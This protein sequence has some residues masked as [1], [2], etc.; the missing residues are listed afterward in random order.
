MDPLPASYYGKLDKSNPV[1]SSFEKDLKE[2]KLHMKRVRDS[3]S[4]D[5]SSFSRGSMKLFDIWKKYEPRLPTPYFHERLLQIADFLFASKFFRLAQWQGY[6]RYLHHFCTSGLE[7]IKDVEQ[8]KQSFFPEGFV[9]EGAKLMFH[10]LQGECLCTF[11]LERERSKRP[12]PSGLQKLLEILTF[13]RI[14]MQAILPH[15]SLCWLLYN[16]SLH[17]YNICR[18]LMSV[19]HAAQALEYLLWACVCLETSVPLLMPRFLPWRATLY[20]AV[21]ECYY[22]GQAAVQAEVFARRALGKVS[23]LG[24]LEELSGSPS[25]AETQRAF[26]EATIKLAVMVF[27]RSVYEPRKKP[28]GLFRPKQKSSLK[29]GHNIPW[30]RTLTEQILMELFE[31]NAAQFLAVLEGLWDSSCRPLHTGMSDEPEIQEVALELIS[32]GIS[33]LSGNGGSSYRIY[34]ESLPPSLNA[35]TSTFTLMEMA[36][37]GKNQIPV[38]SAVK[39]V[40]LLFRYEQWD[41]F[42]SL[43][44]NLMAVLSNLEGHFF[45]KAE[46]ELTL[47]EALE[48]LLL[49]HKVRLGNKDPV[50]TEALNDKDKSVGQVTMTDELLNLVLTL[51]ACVCESAQDIQVD[52]DMVLDIVLFL[53]AKCK[54]VFQRAQARHYDQV[55]YLGKTENQDKWVQTLFLLCEVAQVCQLAE[56]DPVM[57]AEMT[58]RLAMVLESSADSPPQSGIKTASTEYSSLQS[59]P[60]EKQITFMRSQEE[61][62]KMACGVLE[63]GLECLSRGR[64]ASLPCNASAIS[65]TVFLQKCGDAPQSGQPESTSISSVSAL[66]MDLHVELLA[67]HHRVFLKLLDTFPDDENVEGIKKSVV[68]PSE[69]HSKRSKTES[70]LLEKIKKNKVSK[71]LFLIQKALLSYRKDPTSRSTKKLLEEAVVLMEKA[72][73]EEKR[74]AGASS[75]AEVVS[76]RE[77]GS[78]PPPPPVLLSC[79]DWSMTFTPAVYTL[80]EKVCWYRIYGREV[81]GRNYKVRIGDGHLPGTGDTVP[82]RG[83]PLFHISGLETNQKYIFA[84]AAY[85][86]KGNLV[87]NTIG[88]TTRPLLASLPLPLLSTWAHLAQV[89]YRTGQHT[90]AKKACSVIWSHFMLPSASQEPID[91]KEPEGLA[92][93]RLHPEVLKLSSPLMQQFFLSSIFIQTDIHIQERALYCDTLWDESILIWGQEARLA[94]CERMLVAIDLALHLN[95][96]SAA[97]QAIVSCY[98]LLA[99]LVYYQIPSDPVIQVLLKCLMVLQEI[100]AVLKQKR[101]AAT[102]ESLHHMVACITYY[103]AKGLRAFKEYGMASSV[104]EQG[105]KLLQEIF[106]N[107]HQPPSRPAQVEHEGGEKLQKKAVLV[108]EEELC[109][110]LKSLE[111]SALKHKN[112]EVFGN[113]DVITWNREGSPDPDL[114]GYEDPVVLH[115]VI[116]CSP[117]RNAFKE[118]MKFKHK[119]CFIEF[120]VFLLQRAL[121]EDQLELLPQWGQEIF[122][123][124]SRRDEGLIVLKKPQEKMRK[125]LKKFTSSVIEYSNKKQKASSFQSDKQKKVLKKLSGPGTHTSENMW[126]GRDG[127]ALETLLKLLT[128]LVRRHQRRRRL[129]KVCSDEWPWR[130]HINLTLAQAYMGLLKKSREPQAGALQRCYSKMSPLLF[131]LAH[132]G[133]LVKWKHI[134][135][136]LSQ[137]TLKAIPQPKKD[138]VH[139]AKDSQGATN[140]V[141]EETGDSEVDSELDSPR[142]QMTNDSD[143]SEP[144]VPTTLTQC[145]VSQPLDTLVKALVHLRRAMVLAHRGH[146]W[147]SLQW[148]CR[149][150]WDEFSTMVLLVERD[151]PSKLTLD[152]FCTVFTPLLVLASDLLMDMMQRLQQWKVYDGEGE[153][154]EARPLNDGAL[155]DLRWLRN[156]VLH[157]LEL[158]YHQAKWETLANLALVYNS[159]TR[160]HY[161]HMI[162]PVLVHAQRRLL[163]R[164]TYYGGPPVPQPHFIHTETATGEKISCRNYAGKQLFL[165]STSSAEGQHKGTEST[166][167]SE[168]LE[169]AEVRRAMCVV[170][171]PLDI[172]DTLCCFRETLAKSCYTLLTFQHSRTLLKLLLA[173]TQDSL[174][175]SFCKELRRGR[176]EFNIAATTAPSIGPPDLTN[177][178]YSTVGSVYSSPLPLSHIQ[179]VISSYNSSIKYLQANKYTSLQVQALHDLGNLH[180]CNG[181]RKAAH[182]HWSKALDCA[183]QTTGVLE[184][185]DAESWASSSSQQPLAHAGIWGCLQGA[186]LSAK[187]AQYILTSNISQHTKCCLLSAKLFKCLLKASLPHPDNDLEYSSYSIKMELI[188]GA[189]LF[190]E[191][192]WDIAASAVASLG[193]LCRSLYASGHQLMILPLLALYQYIAT[194]VCQDPHLTVGCRILKVKVLT[195]LGLFAEAVTETYSLILGEEVPLFHRSYTGAEKAWAQKKFTNYKPVMDPSNLEAL[196]EVVNRRPS[197]EIMALYGNSLTCHLLLARIQLIVVICN[198][199][200]DLPE[201]LSPEVLESQVGCCVASSSGLPGKESPCRSPTT[202]SKEAQ[203]LQLDPQKD[204]LTLGQVKALMLREASSQL[205]SQLFALQN[206]HTGP[207]ELELAVET[208]LLLSSLSLQQGKTAH[209]ANL[210]ASALRLLQNSP[211][212]QDENP[213]HLHPR[214]PSS[215]LRQSSAKANLQQRALQESD[216]APCPQLLDM[217]AGVEAT[218]RMGRSLWLRCRLTVVQSLTAHVPGTAIY[219]GVDSSVE[220]ARLLKEGLVEAEAWGDPDTQALLLLQEA[221]MNTHCGRPPEESTSILQEAVSLLSGRSALSLRSGLALAKATLLL[222]DLRGSGSQP[223]CLLTQKLLQQQLCTLGEH[224]VLKAGGGLEL[225]STKGLKNIYHPQL[226]L[227]A[228]TTMHLGHYLAAQA[229]M[230]SSE[231]DEDP[232]KPWLAAQEVLQSALII[233][234]ASACRDHQLE[235]DILC[236]KGMVERNLMSLSA[237]QHQAVVETFL[238]SITIT[239]SHNH[240]LQLIHRCYMEMALIYLQQWQKDA[241]LAKPAPPPAPT[242]SDNK[243]QAGKRAMST[244]N[245]N[246]T[247]SESHILLFWVCLRA[248][249]KIMEAITSCSQLCGFTGSIGDQLPLTSLE[250]LPE[251]AANDLLHPC[252]GMEDPLRCRPDSGPDMDSELSSRKDLTWVHLSRYYT[253]LLNLRHISTRTVAE[254]CVEGL[255]S[256]AGDPSLCLKL[257]Q[258]HNFFSCHLEAYR[259]LCVVADPPAALILEPHVMQLPNTVKMSVCQ[260]KQPVSDLYPWATVDSQQLCIQWYRPTLQ[261]SGLTHN[262]TV[263]IFAL[264]KAPLSAMHPNRVAVAELEAGQRLISTD[265]LKALHE[266]LISVCVDAKF[267]STPS[268]SPAPSSTP[269]ISSKQESQRSSKSSNKLD[270]SSYQQQMLLEKTK[271]ICTEI[272]NLLRPDLKSDSVTE[273]P[274][275]PS[276]KTVCDLERCFNP[277]T[278]ATLVDK[279]LSDWLFSLLT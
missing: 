119:S 187:I 11:H 254:K 108:R 66:S 4:F 196:E 164:I 242:K 275:V 262:T 113:C 169:L 277:A 200:Y 95:D 199:I 167:V 60:V 246:L 42:R 150:L 144:V 16:G 122:S 126:R 76:G 184:S 174:E 70:V 121:Q 252:G 176:V 156:L 260:P 100:P 205:N 43:T 15:E 56:M 250:A 2:F 195:E 51:H 231:E 202:N 261:L 239:L 30:P 158:L 85:D 213:P 58:L 135:P 27:K 227:L 38:E 208:R 234:Q 49:T 106:E 44:D 3:P 90:L 78:P 46:L 193:F 20:C 125:D 236:C 188:P 151:A 267:D 39:F 81:E 123:W 241:A 145:I 230:R 91:D 138:P 273:V 61:V 75:P 263:L 232:S 257:A 185:W 265:R 173:G 223:L 94:E 59:T 47:L 211:L 189:D 65:D 148:V 259:E 159:Y 6:R 54:V 137:S 50:M 26:K 32:A 192:E 96:G 233:S 45:R 235:A 24:K 35:I 180:F 243:P 128:P 253:H 249:T 219:P 63:R 64:A 103:V 124:I 115:M 134:P 255:I 101:P 22:D 271:L 7:S 210:T 155:L 147:T 186:L 111:N 1:I 41:A 248:A 198:T 221:K 206:I 220:A 53:W 72:K 28:K 247:V 217:V 163:E 36:T 204:K 52:G 129:R 215:A 222:S 172:E 25:S 264:N 102:T 98:G 132:T 140:I 18:F 279:A 83:Q 130:C 181:N 228:R 67:F 5:H 177:E 110:Q 74:I 276:V 86:A 73:T 268:A 226:P 191:P 114:T 99:P 203:G 62:L 237:F 207:E 216:G 218:E 133:T 8:F 29:E 225:C 154:L 153:Q 209:S 160:E 117:L 71:A 48:H 68:Q 146:L 141:G 97:L 179:T 127:K 224:V 88:E 161:T 168:P 175:V 109:E 152:Q 17:I 201:P 82:S 13:L 229:M 131:S 258:L 37:A 182:S 238:E 149:I 136:E 165:N 256:A 266:Q 107:P 104:I 166:G 240:N 272:R 9:T 112:A 143:S 274:F 139:K 77:D 92:Q 245:K 244:L 197:G 79:T 183:L 118:V 84:V 190:S 34:N 87:G 178:D 120:A 171:V 31:G 80:E 19:S 10:A 93:T 269:S 278:G 89:A 214:T 170:C 69:A 142:T 212:F 40:K 57:V 194:N 157:T 162:T 14:M 251:F 33:I 21:C 105:K 270:T 23:E 55:H 116:C 12:D